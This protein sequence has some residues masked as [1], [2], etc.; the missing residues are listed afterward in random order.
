MLR[1][2]ESM[3][4]GG[5]GCLLRQSPTTLKKS[6]LL[7]QLWGLASWQSPNIQINAAKLLR[8][9]M[10]HQATSSAAAG[11]IIRWL[12]NGRLLTRL[13]EDAVDATA[14]VL[15]NGAV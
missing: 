6:M 10:R 15:S 9:A 8:L 7:T 4:V 14:A 13:L 12:Y 5:R 3:A 1:R 2:T 11:L